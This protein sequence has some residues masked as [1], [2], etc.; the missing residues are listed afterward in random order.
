MEQA[1]AAG[2]FERCSDLMPH[3]EEEFERFRC[4]LESTGGATHGEKQ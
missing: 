4:A 3:V 1:G 2:Q